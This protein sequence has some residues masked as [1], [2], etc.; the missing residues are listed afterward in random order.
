MEAVYQRLGLPVSAEFAECLSQERRR[1]KR[2]QSS[3]V[4]SL[5]E[6]GLTEARLNEELGEIL[7]RFGFRPESVPTDETREML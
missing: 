4:Y 7:D 6:F 1:Q 3:N 5:E 2:Y